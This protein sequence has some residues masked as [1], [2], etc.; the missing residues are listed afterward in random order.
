MARFRAS[1]EDGL[2]S[3][4]FIS[5]GLLSDQQ[6]TRQFLYETILVEPQPRYLAERSLLLIWADPVDMHFSVGKEAQQT[7]TALLMMP[8][9]FERTPPARQVMVPTAF[10]DC[11]KVGPEGRLL[12]PVTEARFGTTVRRPLPTAGRGAAAER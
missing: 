1:G 8:F 3:A 2:L 4:Q 12:P 10:V 11:Q 6:R 7:G 5:G 9:Q